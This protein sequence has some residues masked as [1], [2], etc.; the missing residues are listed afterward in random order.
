MCNTY[1]KNILAETENLLKMI[2]NFDENEIQQQ[3]NVALQN[4]NTELL[5]IDEMMAELD[6][7]F[8][9]HLEYVQSQGGIDSYFN[10]MIMH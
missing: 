2:P 4:I 3:F 6:A 8:N 1:H 5:I 7:E 9:A 10:Y